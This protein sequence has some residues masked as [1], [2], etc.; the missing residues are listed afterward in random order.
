M[1]KT[2]PLFSIITVVFNAV[3]TIENTILSVLQ[4]GFSDYEYIIIDGGSTDGTIDILKKF[5]CQYKKGDML[6]PPILTPFFIFLI[7]SS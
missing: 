3:S 2:P 6:Y 5:M 4:Q 1:I 7:S